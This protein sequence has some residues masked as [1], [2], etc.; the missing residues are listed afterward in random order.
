MTRRT[1]ILAGL[2]AVAVVGIAAGAA[3]ATA[4]ARNGRIAFERY[5][6]SDSPLWAEIYSIDSDGTRERKVSHAP[7][8]YTDSNPD[9]SP[10]GS[11]LVFERCRQADTGTCY[12]YSVNADGSGERRLSPQCGVGFQPSDQGKSCVSTGDFSPVYSPDG[13]SI[14]FARDTWAVAR[15]GAVHPASTVCVANAKLEHVR[16]LLIAGDVTIVAWSP[17][18]KRLAF[19]E[20]AKGPQLFASRGPAI[21]TVDVG[22]PSRVRRVTPRSLPA[23]ADRIDWSPDGSR[24]LFRTRPNTNDFGGNL[25]TIRPDGTGLRQL[26]HVD[27]YDPNAGALWNGSYSPDGS[28]IVFSTEYGAVGARG[29]PDVFM[30]SADGTDVRPVTRELNWEGTPDWGPG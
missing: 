29:L 22:R 20:N 30:M 19:V 7:R 4:P 23:G 1:T 2:V 11:R 6:L 8:G 25:Y 28:S 24:I 12:V 5:R 9:W 3:Q 10:D 17:D 27:P 26:T 15:S 13:R 14:A 16:R 18:G 21:F